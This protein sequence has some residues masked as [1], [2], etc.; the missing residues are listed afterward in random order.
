MLYGVRVRF[1]GEM[2]ADTFT[3]ASAIRRKEVSFAGNI[4]RNVLRPGVKGL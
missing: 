2:Q 1:I 4:N 3:N